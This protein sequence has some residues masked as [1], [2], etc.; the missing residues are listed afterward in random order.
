MALQPFEWRDKPSLIEHLFPVQKYLP[1]PLK[2]EWQAT[3][4]CWCRWV[5]LE[6]QKTSH[7]KQSVHSGLI[8]TSN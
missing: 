8:V 2:N 5:L 3:V 6:R 7:L 4:S 1:R